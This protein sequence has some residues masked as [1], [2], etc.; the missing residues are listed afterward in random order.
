[1]P[2]LRRLSV[3]VLPL[4]AACASKPEEV[5]SDAG[6]PCVPTAEVCDGLDNDCDGDVDEGCEC[7]G[8]QTQACYSGPPATA[9]VGPC[10][11]GTQAC[12][13]GHWGACA[14]EQVPAAEV[15][16]GVDDDCNAQIDDGVAT[17]Y[18]PDVDHDGWG[19]ATGAVHACSAPAG[20]VTVGGD[21]DDGLPNVHPG[22]PEV[23]GNALD[24]DCNGFID[25]ASE[26]C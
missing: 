6:Q 7:Q 8:S 19:A 10:H 20:Y 2:S 5:R 17:T 22:A 11:A 24:D 9:G 23:C 15:C 13:A 3:L 12:V 21:C 25:A 18:Y 1:L 4:L 16:N 26:G 14:G